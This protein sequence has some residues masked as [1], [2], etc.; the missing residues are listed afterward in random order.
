MQPDSRWHTNRV[1]R[2]KELCAGV[3]IISFRDMAEVMTTEFGVLFNRNML[4]AKASRMGLEKASA[5][6]WSDRHRLREVGRKYVRRPRLSKASVTPM[7][8]PEAPQMT[9]DGV[10]AS[11]VSFADLA[12]HH[13][14][15]PYGE[16]YAAV[17]CGADRMERGSD[18]PR[19]FCPYHC[20]IAY[21]PRNK[22]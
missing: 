22:P 5:N 12:A 14:R 21:Q 7:P 8:E 9:A 17:Y 18:T 15:W 11:A 4:I 6:A 1:D 10:P 13:C 3:K 20:G 16:G 2:F 19:A